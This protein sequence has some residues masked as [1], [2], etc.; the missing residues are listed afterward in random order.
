MQAALIERDVFITTP[1]GC[2]KSLPLCASFFEPP[3]KSSPESPWV[4]VVSPVIALMQDQAKMLPR[5]A[6]VVLVVL[7]T[8]EAGDYCS[9]TRHYS[10][11]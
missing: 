6:D 5:V 2:S 9:W 3:G 10:I 1:T 11:L 4:L 7:L 8:K